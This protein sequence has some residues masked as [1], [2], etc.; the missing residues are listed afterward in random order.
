M[1]PV[2]LLG[3][4]I[5]V[6]LPAAAA[7]V[8]LV[9]RVTNENNVPVASA[10]V[11]VHG[12][13]GVAALRLET[14]A[15]PGGAFRFDLLAPGTYLLDAG[16]EG[17]FAVK[18][19][20][21]HLAEGDNEIALTL[22]PRREVFESVNVSAPP[23]GLDPTRTEPIRQLDNKQLEEIPY[24]STNTL[25]NALRAIPGVVQDSQGG[26]HVQ[27]GAEEQTL[28]TLDGFTVSDPLTG[29]FESRL[30]VESV[31]SLEVLGGRLPPE[32]GK[33]SAGVLAIHTA[34]G[35]DKL[36]YGATN[37]FPGIENRKGLV[38]GD[39][40]PRFSLSGPLRRGRAWFSDTVDTQYTL[41]VVDELPVGQDRNSSWRWN[42]LLRNQVNLTPSNILYTS[43]L[44]NYWSASHTGLGLFNPM[45][46]TVDRRSRQWFTS[47][48]DQIYF[49]RG[50]LL[51]VGV[52][53]NRTFGREIPQGDGLYILTPEGQSGNFFADA[54]RKAFRDQFLANVFLPTFTFLG[55]HHVKAGADLDRLQYWQS[56]RRTG[57]EYLRSDSTLVRQVTFGGSGQ[58]RRPNTE[59][60]AY[61]QDSWRLRPRLSLE[62]GLRQDWDRILRDWSY[63]PRVGVAWSPAGLENTKLSAGWGV[64]RDATNLR[65]F[66]R[67]L[68]QYLLTSYYGADGQLEE[69]PAVSLYTIGGARLH[70]PRY[71]IWTTGLEQRLPAN[72]HVALGYV[73][74]RGR[75]GF[76]YFNALSSAGPVNIPQLGGLS[77]YS[78][79]ALYTLGN[80]RRDAYDSFEITV[81]QPIRKQYEWLVSYARS[82]AFSNAVIDASVDQP[83]LVS[84]NVGRMPWDSPN[85]LLSWGYLPTFW[86]N[87]G[88]AYLAE[89]RNGYP[90]SLQDED[91]RVV[92]EV[93]ST[94]FPM[95]FEL[96]LHIERRLIFRG[97]KWA[98]RGGFNNITSH[99]NPNVVNNVIG[100]P[101]FLTY[102]GGQSRALNFRLRWLGKL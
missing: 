69:G 47:V 51:E 102:G 96:N 83:V 78:L 68:D 9:G 44:V 33:G 63:S 8:R 95:F 99:K 2:R 67:P 27:G 10:R 50:T 52:A 94:R 97:Q 14:V 45:E 25:R 92:G 31:E 7:D 74:K 53:A 64:M 12:G 5:A 32:Y 20:P 18:D 22:A 6:V 101:D 37:F 36:H 28:Y 16:K 39:W 86:K 3:A 46:T 66:S 48:K 57:L 23:P 38:I 34:A 58:F 17:Y 73:R 26:V 60:S 24:P 90:F 29:R 15:D 79:D 13:A 65:V 56:V 91:G 77:S 59:A 87:W 55:S 85:R 35:E 72:L 42:N 80:Y 49:G 43:F 93:N 62:I 71:Q 21:V 98:L 76:T 84:D 75:G 100:G 1:V 30:G 11:V 82:R 81:R 89:V 41:H 4:L 54:T 19:R 70:A 40:T 61:F 88:L